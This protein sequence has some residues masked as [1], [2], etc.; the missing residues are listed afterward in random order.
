MARY[1]PARP[2]VQNVPQPP[3][4]VPLEED[5]VLKNWLVDDIHIQ[6]KNSVCHIFKYHKA[7]NETSQVATAKNYRLDSFK[8]LPS[9][10]V[11]APSL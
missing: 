5:Q 10:I 6:T 3:K 2:H 9:T 7:M 1:Q 11:E 4:T 8:Q